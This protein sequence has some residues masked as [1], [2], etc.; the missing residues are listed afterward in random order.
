MKTYSGSIRGAII[1]MTTCLFLSGYASSQAVGA[2]PKP[3][4][5]AG[6]AFVRSRDGLAH[7]II[8]RSPDVG[9]FVWV[10]LS[11]DGVPIGNIGY[12]RNYEGVLPAGRHVLSLLP[13]PNP[14]WRTPSQM[15]LNMRS[16]QTYAF[17][18]TGNSGHLILRAPGEPELPRGR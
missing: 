11:A 6:S 4:Q 7:L 17:T 14:K 8:W 15:I 10:Q 2:D 5:R 16:G 3:R 1:L 13:T 18:V 12:G 9:R